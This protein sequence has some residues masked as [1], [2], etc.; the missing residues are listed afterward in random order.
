MKALTADPVSGTRDMW[1]DPDKAGDIE[2]LNSDESSLPVE[3]A[4]L[5]WNQPPHLQGQQC[6]HLLSPSEGINPTC[7]RKL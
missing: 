6:F 5:Q 2:P 7:L 1:E 3:V 4:S